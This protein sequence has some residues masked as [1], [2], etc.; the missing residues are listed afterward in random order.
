MGG[1]FLDLASHSI[2]PLFQFTIANKLSSAI[3]AMDEDNTYPK[4][5][6][7]ND[8]RGKVEKF[9]NF[10]DGD[11]EVAVGLDESV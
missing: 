5:H 1:A 2:F 9:G 11:V 8:V 10:S 6:P 3:A 7:E 4:F